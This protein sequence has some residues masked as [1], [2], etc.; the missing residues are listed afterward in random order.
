MLHVLRC[1]ELLSTE[2]LCMLCGQESLFVI[3]FTKVVCYVCSR[4]GHIYCMSV[5]HG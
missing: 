5:Q 2:L 1:V 4:L 3:V